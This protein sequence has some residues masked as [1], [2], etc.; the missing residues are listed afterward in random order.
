[1]PRPGLSAV[2]GLEVRRAEEA[3]AVPASAVFQDGAT[4][5]VWV[6]EGGRAQRRPVSVGA[7]GEEAVQV[8]QG[9]RRG[10]RVVVAGADRLQEGQEL[11]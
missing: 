2:V 11:P 7:E 5:A 1:V 8:L 9:L 3:V 10:E 4:R 6:D